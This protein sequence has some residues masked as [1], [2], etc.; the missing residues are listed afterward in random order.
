[1]GSF[2]RVLVTL[3]FVLLAT[4]C[5]NRDEQ[6]PPLDPSASLRVLFVGDGLLA[7]DEF[8][9]H[10]YQL[11][12]S[13]P[14]NE[15]VVTGLSAR[16]V[17]ALPQHPESDPLERKIRSGEYSVVVV[18]GIGG[19]PDCA[20]SARQCSYFESQ[21]R[22]ISDLAAQYGAETIWIAMWHPEPGVDSRHSALVAAIAER[23]GV[24]AVDAGRALHSSEEFRALGQLLSP[25][26]QPKPMGSWYLA[27]LLLAAVQDAPLSAPTGTLSVCDPVM[28]VSDIEIVGADGKSV[29]VVL[30]GEGDSVSIAPTGEWVI[31]SISPCYDS[32]SEDRAAGMIREVNAALGYSQ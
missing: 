2:T 8:R 30:R 13:Q 31:S 32:L 21:L 10:F 20:D 23:A 1:M 11:A 15:R 24:R 25:N 19:W 5:G 17:Y 22:R 3:A 29:G 7:G 6:I 28:V 18:Q 27:A 12:R 16:N 14:G 9:A 4:A 26:L